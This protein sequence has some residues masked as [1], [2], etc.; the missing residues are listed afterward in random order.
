MLI[1]LE[2]LFEGDAITGIPPLADEYGRKAPGV[3]D[4]NGDLCY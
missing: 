1:D 3:Y 2:D 4:A